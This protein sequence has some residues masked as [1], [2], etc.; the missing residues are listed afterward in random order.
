MRKHTAASSDAPL[1]DLTAFTDFLR[2][3]IKTDLQMEPFLEDVSLGQAGQQMPARE[4]L[5]LRGRGNLAD[6]ES[7]QMLVIDRADRV[8]ANVLRPLLLFD[9]GYVSIYPEVI[10]LLYTRLVLDAT[11]D[12]AAVEL[13][14]RQVVDTEGAVR[15]LH[16]D[17]AYE[18]LHKVDVYQRI[19]ERSRSARKMCKTATRETRCATVCQTSPSRKTR[20]RRARHWS[21]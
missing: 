3:A 18:L 9:E 19:F 16:V 12:D 8:P 10:S 1:D 14:V 2:K 13:D 17:L 5:R 6:F 4:Y 20:K 11:P 21:S 15:A 7:L